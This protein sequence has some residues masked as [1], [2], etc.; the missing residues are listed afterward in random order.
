MAGKWGNINLNT[1]KAKDIAQIIE[2]DVKS[3]AKI[4]LM[5][6]IDQ[7]SK[8]ESDKFMD[9]LGDIT[10]I[11]IAKSLPKMFIDALTQEVGEINGSDV[12]RN[13]SDRV[14]APRSKYSKG[15]KIPLGNAAELGQFLEYEFF[16]SEPNW[17]PSPD[18]SFSAI[19]NYIADPIVK[20]KLDV[21]LPKGGNTENL[22]SVL[23]N[24][25][26]RASNFSQREFY[27]WVYDDDGENE[28]RSRMTKAIE[29]GTELK[30]SR[31]SYELR[32]GAVTKKYE[33][34]PG[35]ESLLL[36]ALEKIYEKMNTLLILAY[37][38]EMS[39][40]NGIKE[41]IL[42]TAADLFNELNFDAVINAIASGQIVINAHQRIIAN[43]SDEKPIVVKQVVGFDFSKLKTATNSL[44]ENILRTGVYIRHKN[45]YSS[46]SSRK[47][48]FSKVRV[49]AEALGTTNYGGI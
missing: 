39:S 44:A 33:T 46:S 24:L 9:A 48:F 12:T 3:S 13:W 38:W 11:E 29:S 15:S 10:A 30:T 28:M 1:A 35:E 36:Q 23:K 45:L 20:A 47:E 42:F 6:K 49:Y 43:P 19:A 27:D 22:S 41:R 16:G 5:K 2:K 18:I 25:Q 31:I 37:T 17:N 7:K 40:N 32:M 21:A 26:E 34:E 8:K 4:A 14:G